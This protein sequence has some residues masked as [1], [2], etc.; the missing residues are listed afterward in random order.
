MPSD[1]QEYMESPEFLKAQVVALAE[2]VEESCGVLKGTLE[3][4]A[5]H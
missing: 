2:A 4:Y 1:Y 5:T 3:I